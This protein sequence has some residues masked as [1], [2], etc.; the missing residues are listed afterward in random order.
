MVARTMQKIPTY[1][2][3]NLHGQAREILATATSDLV[4]AGK[5]RPDER[6]LLLEAHDQ[7]ALYLLKL[8]EQEILLSKTVAEIELLRREFAAGG[9]V[10]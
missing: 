3:I 8:H 5:L 10:H 9:A 6:T 1:M 7:T 2:E 4:T